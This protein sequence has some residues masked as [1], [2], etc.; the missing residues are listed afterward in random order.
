MSNF[1]VTYLLK[2]NKGKNRL[3]IEDN[4][5]EEVHIHFGEMRLMLRNAEFKH[6][7][8]NSLE[9]IAE[10]TDIPIDDLRKIEPIFLLDL[11]RKGE[12]PNLILKATEYVPVGELFCPVKSILGVWKY[13]PIYKSHFLKIINGSAESSPFDNEQINYVG[14]NNIDRCIDVLNECRNN[15]RICEEYPL[16]V[17][18]KNIIRDGQHRAV[19]L[20]HLYGHDFKVKIQRIEI[21]DP[22]S[23]QS[24]I[25]RINNNTRCILKNIFFSAIKYKNKSRYSKKQ[26]SDYKSCVKKDVNINAFVELKKDVA[27]RK[28]CF[29]ID[30][31]FAMN[32]F[33]VLVKRK[34]SSNND[35]FKLISDH[36]FFIKPGHI[37]DEISFIY[38]LEEDFLVVDKSNNPVA[39]IQEKLSSYAM[40]VRSFMPYAPEIQRYFESF[41]EVPDSI[42]YVLRLLKCMFD[43][44]KNGFHEA[45]MIYFESCKK[46]LNDPFFRETGMFEKIFFGYTTR[47]LNMLDSGKYID[48]IEDYRRFEY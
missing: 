18:E 17:T 25:G 15:K 36:G 39:F 20:Y 46:I 43:K 23:K 33:P 41:E 22:L 5:G 21:L 12:L 9:Y 45:D 7:A 2:L 38:G 27:L 47:M 32:K 14:K 13:E 42:L 34:H 48:I 19:A 1:G 3:S 8:K 10:L 24:L 26:I 35:V 28:L 4:I 16:Y 44:D 11:C 37:L 40:S 31:D 29:F 6:L 30:G